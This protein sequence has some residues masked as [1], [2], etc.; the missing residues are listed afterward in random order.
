VASLREAMKGIS[1]RKKFLIGVSGGRDSMVLLDA[2]LRL[3]FTNLVVCHIDHTLRGRSSLADARLVKRT[4]KKAGLAL[5]AARCRT[6][7]YAS[8]NQ[9][10]IELAAREL[11]QAFFR[12]CASRHRCYRLLL[13]HHADDQV[14]TCLFNFLRGSGASGL[15]GMRKSSQIGKLEIRRPFLGISRDQILAYQKKYK[16][17][18]REDASN[19]ETRYTRNKI[20]HHVLPRIAEAMGDSFRTAVLRAAFIMREEEDWM[21]SMVPPVGLELSCAALH[22]MH[23]ALQARTVLRW[24]RE[25]GVEEPGFEE[26]RRVLALLDVANGPAKINL[27]GGIHARRRAGILFLEGEGI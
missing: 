4:V 12:E 22:E 23:P 19:E 6:S 24:L 18:Y 20:R 2:L 3:G 7:E 21:S 8:Q 17:A 25:R 14:E 13:A 11:R 27:P 1:P 16:V 5:E 9:K 10:S 26:T 15:G